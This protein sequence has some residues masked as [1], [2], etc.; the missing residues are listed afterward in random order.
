MRDTYRC[1]LLAVEAQERLR[2]N[3]LRGANMLAFF[4]HMKVKPFNCLIFFHMHQETS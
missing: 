1:I 2:P 3:L 4:S